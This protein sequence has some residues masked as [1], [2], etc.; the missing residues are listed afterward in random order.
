MANRIIT[1]WLEDLTAER[2]AVVARGKAEADPG[3]KDALR[4]RYREL[5]WEIA[6]VEALLRADAAIDAAEK[7]GHSG[8]MR[9]SEK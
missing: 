6:R 4:A 7:R 5:G 3:R 8:Q 2:R 9:N 1:D